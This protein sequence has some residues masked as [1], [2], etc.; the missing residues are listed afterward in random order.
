MG[1]ETYG[2]ETPYEQLGIFDD[3]TDEEQIQ[4]LSDSLDDVIASSTSSDPFMELIDA[5]LESDLGTYLELEYQDYDESD[6]LYENLLTRLLKDRNINMT[7]R[8]SD[9]ITNNPDKRFFFTIGSAHFYGADN[10]ITLLEDKG[11]TVTPVDFDEC[12]TCG[13]NEGE[14]KINNRCYV[15][16]SPP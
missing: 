11:Y 5:Y 12:S 3:L 16:Y 4:L 10:I 6:P 15:P 8:I 13:C 1:K 14:E 9:N 7:Q 2:L